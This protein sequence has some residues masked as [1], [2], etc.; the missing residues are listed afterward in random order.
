M[1]LLLQTAAQ[2]AA[3]YGVDCCGICPLGQLSHLLES[4]KKALVPPHGSVITM[5]L[6]YYTGEWRRR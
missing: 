6:P 4:R 5:L 1:N 2:A 3:Q